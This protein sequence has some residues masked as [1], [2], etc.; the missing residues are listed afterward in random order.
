MPIYEYQCA[1]CEGVFEVL[2]PISAAPLTQCAECGG[3]LERLFSS[4]ALNVG[5]YTS[6]AAERHSKKL[7]V[8]QQARQEEDRLLEHA[9]KTGVKYDDLFE[10]HEHH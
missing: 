7:T 6:R 3:R 10:D 4:P 9:R 2:Q 5:H 1:S 8:E